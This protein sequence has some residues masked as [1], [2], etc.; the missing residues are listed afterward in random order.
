MTDKLMDRAAMPN[1][2]IIDGDAERIDAELA[3]VDVGTDPFVAAVRATRM[4]M[5]I[6]NPR[7]DDNPVVFAN[8]AFCRLSGYARE[9]I[10]GR[11]CRFLQ[12]PDTDPE[13]KARVRAA[14][15]AE[16]SVECDIRNYRKDGEPFWNRLLLAPVRDL[17]GNLAYFFASQVDVTLERERLADLESSNAALIAELAGKLREQQANEDELRFTLEAGRFGAWSLDLT[18]NE[19][20]TSATCRE[21]FGRSP[22][23]PFSYAELLEAVHPDDRARMRDAV[24]ASVENR[25]DYD[26]EYRAVTPEGRV[27]W[28]AI[29]ARPTYTDDGVPTR[30]AGVSLDITERMRADRMRRG[31]VE[32]SDAFRDLDDS[33]DISFTAGR[34]LGEALDVDRAGY[35]TVD[36]DAETITIERDWNAPGI[37]SLAGTLNFREYGSY[38]EDLVRGDTV[39]VE[40]ADRDPRTAPTAH[41]LKAIAAH[42]FINMPVVEQG[43]TVALFYLN[44]G[45]ARS[46]SED[47]ATF[48]RE[49][50]DRTR[51]AVERRRAELALRALNETLEARVE[52]RTR[53]L[54]QAEDALRQSQKMEAVGQLTGGLAHDFN[55]MLTG[56]SG[57]LEMMQVRIAQGRYDAIDRYSNAAQGAVRRAAALT[58]RLLAFSR[59]QTLDPKPTNV[60]RLVVGMEELV[61]RTVGPSVH[62]EVVEASS[63][64]ATC[65]DPH[66]L[67]NALL[68]LCINARDAMPDGGRLTIETANKW[69]DDRSAA[70]QDLS[71]GQYV[72]LCVSDTGT[73]MTRD[74]IAKAFDPFFTTKPLGEGTGLGLSMIYGFARQSGGQVRIYSEVGQGTTMCLYLP[75]YDGETVAEAHDGPT[76]LE[77]PSSDG[78]VVLVIDDEP[79]IRMLVGEVLAEGGYSTIE[80]SDGPSGLRI[81]QSDARIDLLIT[82]V[83]LP[84]GLNG[85]QV[86]DAARLV[87]PNLKILFITGYA[88][89]AVVGNGQLDR[90]M[91][92]VTKPFQMETL[93]RKIREALVG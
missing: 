58:H 4:P 48:L 63:L 69:F 39:V 86:A 82:D 64:W 73:G 92:I 54:V 41:A 26:I 7:L 40:D 44:H 43:R 2:R 70:E 93:A 87:R 24:A 51:V 47:E 37:Q 56:I 89:N 30:M 33:A 32:L 9:E 22:D 85:R 53:Q 23:E 38:I 72:S 42:S 52:E 66:Q 45:S 21:N 76:T 59:R 88:E 15:Q 90:D 19:L 49:V 71:P 61:R 46:W 65:V 75:R 79:T 34:I 80:A 18:S 14:V 84:G 17:E 25:T 13:T 35:G 78:E 81:L 36:P 27:R 55:N 62:L 68:N 29:R 16:R 83:G 50:A 10:L 3:G 6:T 91:S 74:V 77:V 11:N 31:L 12:G 5:I 8:D 60:N 57:S 20:T 28:V 1:A 67:E